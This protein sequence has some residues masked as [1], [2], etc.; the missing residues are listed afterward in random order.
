V[1]SYLRPVFGGPGRRERH[2]DSHA[3]LEPQRVTG[4]LAGRGELRGAGRCRHWLKVG[5][6]KAHVKSQE[7][8]TLRSTMKKKVCVIL[9]AGASAVTRQ[10]PRENPRAR[11]GMTENGFYVIYAPAW[12]VPPV[13]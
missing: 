4:R 3:D 6:G 5:R 11:R 2:P 9:G 10:P 7:S 12:M 8:D 13:Q 1:L